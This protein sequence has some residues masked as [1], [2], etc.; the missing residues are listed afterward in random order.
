MKILQ[1]LFLLLSLQFFPQKG[2][3]LI[4]NKKTVI[5][6]RLINNLIFIPVNVNGVE[7]TF[8][9]D[10]GVTE[11]LLFSLDDK[12]VSFSDVEKKKFTGL[13]GNFEIE[14]LVAIN[15][16]VKIGENY[17]DPQHQIYIILDEEF[18]LSSHIGIPVNGIIGY[19][20]FKNHQL[21]INYET[22]K[23]TVYENARKFEK[24]IKKYQHLPMSIELNKPYIT[25]NL[26][27][28]IEARP[29]KMLI[30]LGN[31]DGIWL[32]PS[33]I[34]DFVYN[35]PNIE[36]F[37]GRGF[38]GDIFGK[39]SRIHSLGIGKYTFKK[40]LVAMPDEF[41]IQHLKLVPD[42]K[43]SV[44]SEILRR[45]TIIMDYPGNA[46]YFKGNRHLNDPFHFNMSGLD[47]KHD[48]MIWTEQRVQIANKKSTENSF[49]E[50]PVYVAQNQFQYQFV[51]K[52][53]Y[54]V[55]GSRSESAAYKAGVRKGDVLVRINN[56]KTSE[57]TLQNI[58]DIFKSEEGKM[59]KLEILR[60]NL[61]QIINFRL[62][63]PIPYQE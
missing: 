53:S 49:E 20:L 9:L 30:D 28:S 33:L 34:P 19:H 31:S 52:P 43:G 46:F 17:L 45:M 6:F 51:L 35:R 25:T 61:P 41:S 57:M 59:I 10:S 23:I 38:N 22:K 56:S 27:Q 21:K 14:G 36:D 8:L 40:P 44:G 2:F 12:E 39:R 4:E 5:P 13:G 29:S 48:G 26:Q 54:S 58:N 18:N 15:N 16:K 7:L 63:D 32:F 62:E 11:T 37:L 3:Q 1:V 42:R 47:I 60:N 50:K 55:A 24:E